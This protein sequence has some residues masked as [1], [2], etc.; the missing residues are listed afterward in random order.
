MR[1]FPVFF[2]I[3]VPYEVECDW[4]IALAY[5]LLHETG[6]NLPRVLSLGSIA[7]HKRQQ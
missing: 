2:E 3:S 6:D 7:K 1:T 4:A 5:L